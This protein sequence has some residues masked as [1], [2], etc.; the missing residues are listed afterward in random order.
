MVL[1][2][3][4]FAH[5][6]IVL[7]CLSL[8]TA[9]ETVLLDFSSSSC[10]PCQQMRPTV[11]RLIASGYRVHEIDIH[12]EPQVAARFQ[13]TQV[14]TFIVLVEG[15]E[16]SRSVGLTSYQQLRQMLTQQLPAPMGRPEPQGQLPGS[17]F[18]A[19]V[20]S[21]SQTTFAN[22]DVSTPQSGR[23]VAIQDP[24][25]TAVAPAR[26][27]AS[28][29]PFSS[30]PQGQAAPSAGSPVEHKRLIEA[31]VKISVQD[32]D[33]ISA[34]T[35][36]IVDARSGEALVLTCG[37]LFR[38]SEG[39]GAITVT[40]FQ[41]GPA[42]A[43][44]RTTA[45]GRLI[46]FDLDRD[47]ALLSIRTDVPVEPVSIAQRDTP[48]APGGG[49]TSVGCN[50][51]ANPTAIGSR[52]TT[53]NRYQGHPNVE[54]AGAPVEGRSGGGLFN[55][56][57]Q[58]IGVCFAADPEA[59]EGL[60]ASLP[61]IL[62]KLDSLGLSMVYQSAAPET[63]VAPATQAAAAPLPPQSLPP[64]ADPGFA[65]RGQEPM[66]NSPSAPP[67]VAQ[68]PPRIAPNQLS[69]AEQATLEEIQRRS[70]N[71]EVICIIRPKTPDGNS[72]VISLG[73]ASPHLVR[74]LAEMSASRAPATR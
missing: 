12:R 18:S 40:L 44:V 43:E 52:I 49:V 33:G 34:G 64:Q 16:T 38:T 24:A 29:N 14:P 41:A 65:V 10:M 37:H 9:A 70:E 13:V 63:S 32:P 50:L 39:K 72:E 62:D 47:L 56:T 5:S 11:Q 74:A 35:G 31:S 17:A 4:V 2:R 27:P 66:A 3:N 73:N 42:G 30:V 22:N 1:S 26:P 51:G 15:R 8:P 59:N 25:L 61:S 60:Y 7:V 46:D 69:P 23:I 36:T 21:G 48:L 19:G 55:A 71:S 68:A 6:L 58:L 57:G 28:A 67:L 53:I 20:A 54:V 45:T